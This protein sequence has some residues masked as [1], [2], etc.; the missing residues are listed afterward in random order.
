MRER[1]NI[2]LVALWILAPVGLA[3]GVGGQVAI[4]LMRLS[5]SGMYGLFGGAA[6]DYQLFDQVVG[7][8]DYALPAL[9]WAGLLA[10]VALVFFHALRWRRRT[11]Q[12]HPIE[13]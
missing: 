2:A 8:V 5:P 13:P 1:R 11:H 9:V 10:V 4:T 12:A 3:L 7:I 6:L